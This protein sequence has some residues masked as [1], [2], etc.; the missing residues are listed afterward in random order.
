MHSI[1]LTVV[2]ILFDLELDN[3]FINVYKYVLVVYRNTWNKL[4]IKNEILVKKCIL[5]PFC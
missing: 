1:K 4:K 2:C 5:F 3:K